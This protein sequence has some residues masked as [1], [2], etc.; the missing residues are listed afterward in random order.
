MLKIGAFRGYYYNTN[1]VEDLTNVIAPPYDVVNNEER[2]ILANRSKYNFIKMTLPSDY[3]PS[4]SSN[5]QFYSEAK[6]R[7][8]IWKKNNVITLSKPSVWLL[9]ESYISKNNENLTRSGFMA[10]LNVGD[11]SDKF[12][13]KHEKTHQAPKMDRVNLYKAT[14]SNLS[15]LFFIYQDDLE[16]TKEFINH[17][18]KMNVKS[19]IFNHRGKVN[20]ELMKSSDIGFI[21]KFS[22]SFIDKYAL[23]ADGHHRYAASRILNQE[24]TLSNIDTSSLM[25]YLVPSSTPGLVIEA[26]HRAIHNLNGFDEEIFIQ[27][28]NEFFALDSDKINSSSFSIH[29]KNKGEIKLTPTQQ[30]LKFVE[31]IVENQFLSK[32]PVVILEE[33]ILK[34]INSMS[35]DDISHRKNLKYFQNKNMC[36]QELQNDNWN[37]AI[38]VPPLSVDEIFKVT[39]SGAIF[40]QKSTYFYPKAPTG[41]VMRSM[42]K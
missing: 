12:V 15:P 32:I 38:T 24:N 40:P 10:S 5:E 29:T 39:K 19:A 25:A 1:I 18:N 36:S 4:N 6:K 2:G 7:W 17:F 28:I 31:S 37:F 33:I 42:E 26:T 20:L 27:K 3:D 11:E 30:T 22:D 16:Q 41:L 21:K 13:L 35:S 34:K 14:L 23:I 9:N 8:N